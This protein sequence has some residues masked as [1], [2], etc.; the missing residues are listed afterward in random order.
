DHCRRAGC[1]T[2][3][4]STGEERTDIIPWYERRGYRI[5]S[6][7]VSTDAAF[8]RPMPGGASQTNLNKP[9]TEPSR[10]NVHRSIAGIYLSTGIINLWAAITIPQK[11]TI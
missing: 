10:D 11:G 2:M 3:T 5:R 4:L 1:S 6:V 9:R 8:K 7:E